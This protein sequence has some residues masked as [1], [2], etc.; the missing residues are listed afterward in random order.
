MN[1]ANGLEAS[2][3]QNVSLTFNASSCPIG[4]YLFGIPNKVDCWQ[5]KDCNFF[6]RF[7]LGEFVELSLFELSYLK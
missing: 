7:P 6:Y 3:R 2:G 1:L 5:F 4:R